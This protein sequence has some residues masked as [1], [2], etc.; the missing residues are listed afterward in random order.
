MNERP[1][2]TAFLGLPKLDQ[3]CGRCGWEYMGFHICF[4]KSKPEPGTVTQMQK[5]PGGS[6]PAKPRTKPT[7][8]PRT[9]RARRRDTSKDPGIVEAYKGGA[10]MRDIA[11]E[12]AVGYQTVK[13]IINET[14]ARTGEQ[15]MRAKGVN[16]RFVTGKYRE[17]TRERDERIIALYKEN[18]GLVAVSQELGVDEQT[19]ANV[20][21][22]REEE[23][24]EKIMRPAH[25]NLRW[26]REE[27]E[28]GLAS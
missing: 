25:V 2:P 20:I 5:S 3:P 23:T 13:N 28:D 11:K 9:D 27:D 18:K 10:T 15:I 21:K 26:N 1:D 16:A 14:E 4:D 6:K 17:E 8:Q 12:F 7:Y 19:V 24:G 22:R